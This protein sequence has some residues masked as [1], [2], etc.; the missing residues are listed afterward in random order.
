[1]VLEKRSFDI[2]QNS[3]LIFLYYYSMCYSVY[4]LLRTIHVHNSYVQ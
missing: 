3:F 1:M 4:E 2:Y